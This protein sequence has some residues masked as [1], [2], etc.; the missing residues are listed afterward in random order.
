M[1]DRF[2]DFRDYAAVTLMGWAARLATRQYRETLAEYV[3][4][5][6]I[7]EEMHPE[8]DACR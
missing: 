7:H 1:R 8:W 6:M 3:T 2:N 4:I 5:G